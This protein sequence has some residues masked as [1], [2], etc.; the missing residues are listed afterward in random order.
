ML[1]ERLAP[2]SIYR[3]LAEHGH[4]LFG[5]D[6]FADLFTDSRRGR[7]T[8]PART[9]A[10]VMVLQSFEGLSDQEAVD[11]LSFDLRW[12]AAAGLPAAS[13]SFHP[14]VLTGMRNRLR[15]SDRERRL[16]EDSV[17][18][19]KATGVV[20]RR[21][22][23]LDSTPLFDSVATQDTVT[24]LRAAIRGVLREAP[25]EVAFKVRSALQRDDD[26]ASAGKPPCDWDDPAAREALVDA[27]VKDA[28]AVLG[29]LEEVD[30]PPDARQAAELLAVVAG[31]DVCQ[32]EDGTFAIAR[33]V[34]R[35]RVIST[36]DPQARHGH[37]SRARTFDGYKAHI[38]LDPDSEIITAVTATPAN[39][40]DREVIDSLIEDEH[41]EQEQPVIVGD[42]AYADGATLARIAAA[43]RE[44][45]SKVPPVRNPNGFSKDSFAI[46]LDAQTVTCPAGNATSILTTRSGARASFAPWCG[47][48]PLRPACTKSRRGRVVT[49]HANEDVLQAA[50]LRQKQ[51][52]WQQTY[53]QTRPTVE[54]KF[55]HFTRRL[56]GG[57]K[58][59]CRGLRRI[60]TDVDTRAGVL[61]LARM[62]VLGLRWE[63]NG[64][65]TG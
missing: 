38:A 15:A 3:M 64:W 11:R 58:A 32:R 2:G 50:K 43:G 1:G 53:R 13:T 23:V 28:N 54:R 26:Y 59:R 10:T 61:N 65:A 34:A 37:K 4:H 47:S 33:G 24:Q 16:F 41:G 49:I 20:G 31:Q 52:A 63:P 57:R 25:K 62:A 46:D 30:L 40:A 55:A 27:L 39:T 6:Y 18:I 48:C 35:D 51:A 42:S 7:P 17:A 9:V 5:D 8:I 44:I 19:A 36:V 56:W 22:R 21:V 45:L 29:A 14:T 12:Q 60:A